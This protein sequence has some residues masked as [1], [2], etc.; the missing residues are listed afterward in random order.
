MESMIKTEEININLTF[1]ISFHV[2]PERERQPK[3]IKTP[4]GEI[5]E[6][7]EIHDTINHKR[8]PI[9]T[10]VHQFNRVGEHIKE[11]FPK[12]V[13]LGN[14][15]KPKCVGEF[16]VFTYGLCDEGK[17]IYFTNVDKK[18]CFPQLNRLYYFLVDEIIKYDTLE[19]LER[20][21]R[22]YTQRKIPFLNS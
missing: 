17:T 4:D 11:I 14:Y 15:E 12:A 6:D 7:P 16:T 10:F 3:M 9:D 19:L 22:E 8:F 13:V 5:E 18:T 20:R 1:F 21:Q 2:K